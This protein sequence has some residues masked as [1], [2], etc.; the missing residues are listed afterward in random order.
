ML[1]R[2]IDVAAQDVQAAINAAGGYLPRRSAKSAQSQQGRS[3]PTPILTLAI[4]S[5]SLPL[6][7]VNDFADTILAQKLGR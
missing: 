3:G 4:T 1:D 5:D 6:D 7:K 2:P